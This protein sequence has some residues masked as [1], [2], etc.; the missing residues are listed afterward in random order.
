MLTIAEKQPYS[1]KYIYPVK[2]VFWLMQDQYHKF[3][4]NIRWKFSFTLSTKLKKNRNEKGISEK[5]TR[6]AIKNLNF[7][8][9]FMNCLR[10]HGCIWIFMPFTTSFTFILLDPFFIN[11]IRVFFKPERTL[12]VPHTHLTC[13]LTPPVKT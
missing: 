12:S 13:Y 1:G 11:R 10:V 4:F 8:T 7:G 2:K 5:K 6:M 9:H 3:I